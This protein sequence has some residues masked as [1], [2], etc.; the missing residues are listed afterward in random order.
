MK[1]THHFIAATIFLLNSCFLSAQ[2]LPVKNAFQT[3]LANVINEYPNHF[4]FYLGDQL[5]KNPQSSDYRCT[6]TVKDAEEC[7]ITQYSAANKE[8]VSW[9]A[10]MRRTENFEAAEKKFHSLY[11]SMNNLSASIEPGKLIFKGTYLRPTE[12]KKFTSILFTSD[13]K[14]SQA[15]KIVIELLLQSE[16]ME[17]T[18]RILV[19][20]KERRDEERG[21]TTEQ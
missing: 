15:N 20:E 10:M 13:K 14:Y 19:Y 1:K 5:A 7:T 9:Q 17:W 4:K 11:N 16:M 12:E 18:I 8:V 2:I 6:L 3:D 21:N